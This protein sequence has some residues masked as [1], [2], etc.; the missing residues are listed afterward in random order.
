MSKTIW[1]SAD[2][3][4]SGGAAKWTDRELVEVFEFSPEIYKTEFEKLKDKNSF[5]VLES[6]NTIFGSGAFGSF[7]LAKEI[8]FIKGLAYA[9]NIAVIE[10]GNTPKEWKSPWKDILIKKKDEKW[11]AGE[12]KKRSIELVKELYPKVKITKIEHLKTKDKE[13]YLDGICDA[14]LIGRSFIERGLIDEYL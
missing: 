14:I 5:I 12:A 7:K 10:K 9:N 6:I 4:A 3:G 1:L 2:P 8:G 11:P 13:I